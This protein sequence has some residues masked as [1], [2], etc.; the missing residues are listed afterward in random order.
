[1]RGVRQKDVRPVKKGKEEKISLYGLEGTAF[2]APLG[3]D[4]V[5]KSAW[6]VGKSID[7]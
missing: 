6:K 4:R 3:S 7:T 1:M 5:F 2:K